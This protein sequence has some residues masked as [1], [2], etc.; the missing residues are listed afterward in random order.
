M[1]VHGS[2][3]RFFVFL[4]FVCDVLCFVLM[5]FCFFCVFVF[6][7]LCVCFLIFVMLLIVFRTLHRDRFIDKSLICYYVF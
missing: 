1:V 3:V 2:G 4:M 6:V 5:L 7:F